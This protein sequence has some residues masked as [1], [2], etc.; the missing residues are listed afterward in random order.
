MHALLKEFEFHHLWINAF[1]EMY[2]FFLF[3]FLYSYCFLCIQSLF[4]FCYLWKKLHSLI[5][6]ILLCNSEYEGS[7]KNCIQVKMGS[8]CF[9]I[10]VHIFF[11][12]IF[13]FNNIKKKKVYLLSSYTSSL[14]I[15]LHTLCLLIFQKCNGKGTSSPLK[16]GLQ[17]VSIKL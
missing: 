9:L 5:I 4:T 12:K 3:F 15:L 14:H 2:G 13:V 7:N 11:I 1:F 10:S 6:H 8:T 16:S 17:V